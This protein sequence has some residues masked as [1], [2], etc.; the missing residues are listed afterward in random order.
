MNLFQVLECGTTM[1][2]LIKAIKFVINVIRWAVPIVLIVLGSIDLFKAMASNKDD[3][4]KKAQKTLIRRAIYGVVI[5]LIPFLVDLTF[6]V[7][8]QMID[9]NDS[10]ENE[11]ELAKLNEVKQD[12]FFKCWANFGE[13][14]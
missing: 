9:N 14:D 10:E 13:G 7:V 6:S 4:A 8:G 1:D 12:N 5:F 3:E 2:T 11:N